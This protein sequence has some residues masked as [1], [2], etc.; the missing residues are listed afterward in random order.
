MSPFYCI[1]CKFHEET[2]QNAFKVMTAASWTGMNLQEMLAK[3]V[4]QTS[5]EEQAVTARQLCNIKILKPGIHSS[6]I[7]KTS[8]IIAS[9]VFIVNF[10]S[11]FKAS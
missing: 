4:I 9:E 7:Q 1:S 10:R 6:L 11:C 3:H 5:D 2:Q 8:P